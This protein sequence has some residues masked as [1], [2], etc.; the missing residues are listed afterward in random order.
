[1]ILGRFVGVWSKLLRRLELTMQK[2]DFAPPSK[3]SSNTR[4]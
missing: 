1:M 2:I 3:I 4:R